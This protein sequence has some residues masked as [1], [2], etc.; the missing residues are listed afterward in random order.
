MPSVSEIDVEMKR[1]SRDW[2]HP[3]EFPKGS[4]GQGTFN[5]L[6]NFIDNYMKRR[7]S[8]QLGLAIT[9][10]R[11]LGEMTSLASWVTPSPF[12]N[13]LQEVVRD[14]SPSPGFTWPT[15]KRTIISIGIS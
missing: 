13:A 15:H 2:T 4:I 14:G 9:F 5:D 8:P 10:E 12:G 7:P 6:W 3:P 1:W 11:I